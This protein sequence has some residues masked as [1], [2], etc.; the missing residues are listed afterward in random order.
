MTN[1]LSQYLNS[2][3]STLLYNGAYTKTLTFRIFLFIFIF[4]IF[5]SILLIRTTKS[6]PTISWWHIHWLN[7]LSQIFD[8]VTLKPQTTNNKSLHVNFVAK[9][10][11]FSHTN[12]AKKRGQKCNGNRWQMGHQLIQVPQYATVV[13]NKSRQQ[14]NICAYEDFLLLI[15]EIAEKTRIKRRARTLK[16]DAAS[17][18]TYTYIR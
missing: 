2:L 17:W 11:I 12:H 14:R 6:M 5:P 13:V 16:E 18:A 1:A 10:I 4:R 8:K 3:Y 15:P 9:K 7:N